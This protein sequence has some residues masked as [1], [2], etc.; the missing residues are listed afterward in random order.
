MIISTDFQEFNFK[1]FRIFENVSNTWK[2]SIF[3]FEIAIFF[4]VNYKYSILILKELYNKY[5]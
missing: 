4:I 5:R 1:K 2:N 3:V